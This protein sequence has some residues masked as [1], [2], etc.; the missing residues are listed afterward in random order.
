MITKR[1]F[2]FPVATLFAEADLILTTAESAAESLLINARL[3]DGHVADT[4]LLFTTLNPESAD[5]Q[6]IRGQLGTMTVAQRTAIKKVSKIKSLA[7][8]SAK[9][10]YRGQ[11]VLL[12][13][14]FLVGNDGP[15]DIATMLT[16]ADTIQQSCAN[17]LHAAAL[18]S[19]G[20]IAA[21]NVAFA[22]AI[23]AARTAFKDKMDTKADSGDETNQSTQTAND[24]YLGI[25][26]IQNAAN[27]QHDEEHPENRGIRNK[28]RLGL[29]PPPNSAANDLPKPDSSN[30]ANLQ[31]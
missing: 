20:W 12:H 7:R 13:E 15:A 14:T 19:Q 23:D 27:I 6:I 16:R 10:A 3:D 8:K 25:L 22:A 11:T 2:T 31:P 26:A 30:T 5:K 28:Y 24:L 21:D 17:P 1:I 18:K 9:L 29:F 4:R